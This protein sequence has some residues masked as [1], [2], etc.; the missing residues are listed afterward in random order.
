VPKDYL[1]AYK[2]YAL[3]AAQD[4][5]HA[6]DIKVSLAR[7]E[8]Q[9]TKAQIAEA[10]RLAR[11]YKSAEESDTARQTQPAVSAPATHESGKMGM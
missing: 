8:S 7:L 6:V 2:W 3:S 4:N 11:D 1:Q 10:Q 5:E 9:L